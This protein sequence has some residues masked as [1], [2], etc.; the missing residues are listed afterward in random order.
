MA[1]HPTDDETYG[2]LLLSDY[3]KAE[4][5][6]RRRISAA[7]MLAVTGLAAVAWFGTFDLLD[8]VLGQV[9]MTVGPTG[10]L[11][12]R[13]LGWVVVV[14]LLVASRGR[15]RRNVIVAV[16]AAPLFVVV[17]I[18][19]GFAA[20]DLTGIGAWPLHVVHGIWIL[21]MIAGV[22]YRYRL[23]SMLAIRETRRL[24]TEDPFLAA[25]IP[26]VRD[27]RDAARTKTDSAAR[28]RFA[29]GLGPRL[30]ELTGL[31]RDPEQLLVMSALSRAIEYRED[32]VRRFFGFGQ[33]AKVD[34]ALR[35]ASRWS[36]LV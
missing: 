25:A 33:T 8:A 3:V 6:R 36:M 4:A 5:R 21:T 31:A 27:Y 1:Y 28:R 34:Q 26:F 19:G 17:W 12:G 24:A 20:Y 30:E 14:L 32:G 23:P 35:R 11:V 13:V 10:I 22:V 29:D 16:M 15:R 9:R 2:R 7:V 18:V